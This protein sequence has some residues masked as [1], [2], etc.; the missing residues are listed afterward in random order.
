MEDYS[1]VLKGDQTGSVLLPALK[2]EFLVG[3][4]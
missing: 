1:V 3:V 4:I 2:I